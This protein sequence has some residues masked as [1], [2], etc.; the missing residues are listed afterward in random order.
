[1][2]Q[3]RIAVEELT[4][5]P[6]KTKA[7][8]VIGKVTEKHIPLI[9]VKLDEIYVKEIQTKM[10]YAPEEQRKALWSSW[11]LT[12]YFE[13]VQD[14]ISKDENEDEEAD[15][16]NLFTSPAPK[17]Q[18]LEVHMELNGETKFESVETLQQMELEPGT[19]FGLEA[20]VLYTPQELAV[21][22]VPN[23][24]TKKEDQVFALSILLADRTGPITLEYWRDD[25]EK[26]HALLRKWEKEK[27]NPQQPLIVEV[28]RFAL[29]NDSRTHHTAMRKM[30]GTNKTMMKKKTSQHR[31][32]CV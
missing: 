31:M 15:F 3:P 20:Y 4:S 16:D 19:A 8:K 27:T 13:V 22:K 9:D 17:R 5:V 28:E 24:I 29:Q 6:E 23:K 12:N 11:L 21:R 18:R 14:I 10:S 1:M 30:I 26:T 2:F 32:R 7:N 25:A